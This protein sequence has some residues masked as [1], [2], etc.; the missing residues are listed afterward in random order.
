MLM[1]KGEYF[2]DNE[3][4]IDLNYEFLTENFFIHASQTPTET[5]A[6]TAKTP[7]ETTQ[8][9]KFKISCP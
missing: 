2:A 8:V 3:D 9:E 4:N 5:P 7:A 6:E 1:A